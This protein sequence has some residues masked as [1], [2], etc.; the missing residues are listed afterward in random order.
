MAILASIWWPVG[1]AL[2]TAYSVSLARDIMREKSPSSGTTR[3]F[4]RG[5]DD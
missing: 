3:V 4:T 1:F 5:S 2:A